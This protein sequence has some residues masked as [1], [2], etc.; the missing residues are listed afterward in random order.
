MNIDKEKLRRNVVRVA[1]VLLLAVIAT[2]V[3]LY[4]VPVR[5]GAMDDII[6]YIVQNPYEEHPISDDD[7]DKLVT[8]LKSH[9]FRRI[10]KCQDGYWGDKTVAIQFATKAGHFIQVIYTLYYP[11]FSR[12]GFDNTFYRLSSADRAFLHDLIFGDSE[13]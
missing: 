12:I 3:I 8:Y 6:D 11:S 2:I 4:T 10:I 1:K 7:F 5:L 9:R 13:E